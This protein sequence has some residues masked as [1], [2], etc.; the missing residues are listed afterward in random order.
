MN[1][2][3]TPIES[4]LGHV[5]VCNRQHVAGWVNPL[6]DNGEPATLC[7]LQNGVPLAHI[8]ADL[9][10]ADLQA[11]RQGFCAFEYIFPE[12]FNYEGGV[13]E[14]INVST[15]TPLPGSPISVDPIAA[16]LHGTID[17]VDKK[18][19]AGWI[20][21]KL[22][23]DRVVWLTLWINGEFIDHIA[24]NQFRRDLRD[25]GLG[26]GRYGF[27][28]I[29]KDPLLPNASY[30]LQLKHGTETFGQPLH[31]STSQE[32]DLDTQDHLSAILQNLR[33]HQAQT[34]ALLFLNQEISK[35]KRQV[36]HSTVQHFERT[37]STRLGRRYEDFPPPPPCVL[38]IDDRAPNLNFDAGSH[39]LL[40]HMQA[41]QSLGYK[42]L[43]ISSRKTI[44]H[45]EI[46]SLEKQGFEAL[47]APFFNTPEEALKL[48]GTDL[49]AIYLH[50]LN[51][52]ES[53]S[54]LIRAFAPTATL[55]W[56]IADLSS[57]RL[58]RQAEVETRPEILQTVPTLEVRENMC[59]WVA[60][61]TITHSPIETERLKTLVPVANI[62]TI[63]WGVPILNAR[64]SLKKQPVLV[65]LAHFAHS[66]NIDGAKWFAF[67]ILPL[68][69]EKLPNVICRFI[70]SAMPH[71]IHTLKQ[72]GLEILGHIPN[73][74]EALKGAAMCIAPLR[75][76]SG[77]KGKVLESWSYGLPIAMT[78]TAAEGI[79]NSTHPLWD[80]SVGETEEQFVNK[81]LALLVPKNAKL[82]IKEGQKLLKQSFSQEI[83]Q[84]KISHFL[85]PVENDTLPRDNTRPS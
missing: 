39:A 12:R 67:K 26:S 14:V 71:E 13:I 36:S 77:I 84:E 17:I 19:I 55:I 73:L 7:I 33:N 31:L 60:D 28:Y 22:S 64:A 20:Y 49:T 18:H 23:P 53:Y 32:L 66:P 44:S 30:T 1:T 46:T 58:R 76:G 42:C 63:P 78:P 24:A 81:I 65:F 54:S 85:P 62:H 5:D 80:L 25:I 69:R 51:N 47:T 48:I 56:S 9:F 74:S 79:I 37:V 6:T 45:D 61:I 4:L 59:S 68:L 40:S 50:R 72:P 29:F 11:I 27:D 16:E 82:C 10:R 15:Q 8:V 43:F 21:D 41:A 57:L 70:G 3:I 52:A 35:L 2:P 75:Y 38:F 34:D 83:V